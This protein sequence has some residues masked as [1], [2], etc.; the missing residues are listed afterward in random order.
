MCIRDRNKRV[1]DYID[2]LVPTWRE[3]FTFALEV[4]GYDVAESDIVVAF[5]KPATVQ[6][7]TEATITGT[8]VASG[9][10]LLEALR[11]ENIDEAVIKRI[12]AA[13]D[14]EKID[15]SRALPLGDITRLVPEPDPIVGEGDG[16]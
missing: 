3:V 8:R 9:V 7:S 2:A 5:D 14:E 1:Q 4:L 11:M 16:G 15:N 13:L 10:P 12:A 6:P